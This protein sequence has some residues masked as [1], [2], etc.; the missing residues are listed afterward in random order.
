MVQVAR[1][2]AVT[3]VLVSFI[4]GGFIFAST[5]V[6]ANSAC[7]DALNEQLARMVRLEARV[8]SAP[9]DLRDPGRLERDD[10]VP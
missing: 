3:A 9:R 2:A 4:L 7:Q 5:W 8:R 6:Q 1:I 10:I